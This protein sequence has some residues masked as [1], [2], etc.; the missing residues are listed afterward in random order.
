VIIEVKRVKIING[1]PDFEDY[2]WTLF[3]V[4]NSMKFVNSGNF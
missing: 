4:F 2:G 1:Q 3:P